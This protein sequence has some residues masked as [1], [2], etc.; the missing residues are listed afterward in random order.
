MNEL[1]TTKQKS[2]FK[3]FDL[4]VINETFSCL[5][6]DNKVVIVNGATKD[7]NDRRK[8][9]G[10]TLLLLGIQTIKSKPMYIEIWSCYYDNHLTTFQVYD[11]E[12]NFYYK[13][14]RF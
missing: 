7:I 1:K 11:N 9:Y 5:V 8:R 3:K 2:K 14:I 13:L 10:K 6:I 12:G 4:I